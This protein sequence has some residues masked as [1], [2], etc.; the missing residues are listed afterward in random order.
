MPEA[1]L[2]SQPFA[3]ERCL[4]PPGEGGTGHGQGRSALS[5]SEDPAQLL[6]ALSLLSPG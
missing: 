4:L 5:P 2:T 1:W 3:A 6:L